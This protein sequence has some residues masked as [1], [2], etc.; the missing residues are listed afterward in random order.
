MRR[1]TCLLLAACT[2]AAQ[3]FPRGKVI[4]R[5]TVRD[6]DDQSYALYLPS[7]YSPDRPWPILYCLDPGARGRVPVERFSQAAE[8]SGF[9]VVGSNNSRNGPIAVSDTAI[10][11]ML[12]DTGTRF[13]IDESRIYAAG[14]SGGARLALAW[15]SNGRIKGVVASSAGFGAASPPKQIPFLIFATAGYD[16]FNYD[17]LY[18][19]S[20]ELAK[21][22]TPHRFREFE[23]GHEWL[24]APLAAEALEFFLGHVPPQPAPASKEEEKLAAQFDRLSR[25]AVTAE[26]GARL[27]LIRQLQK[28]AAS[29]D[30]SGARRVARRVIG[31]LNVGALEQGRELMSNHN[32]SAAA[33]IYET[34]VLLRPENA[35]A[36]YTLATA[37]AGAGNSRRALEALE[38][39]AQ[40]G[41]HDAG[42]VEQEPLFAKLR[43]DARF[44]ALLQKM[45]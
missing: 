11:L 6:H 26:D 29:P 44:Q 9:L 21:R 13:A 17:E 41:F 14:L 7:N 40:H 19:M 16:D 31:G 45:R 42:R 39:A 1:L 37:Q 18:R 34:S 15:A 8:K 30:D 4:E 10:R 23:G 35:N 33:R 27:T 36:W 5:V 32:Y 38:Q 22:G 25:E 28:D 24:P 3:E 12:A 2:L 43:R 20:R